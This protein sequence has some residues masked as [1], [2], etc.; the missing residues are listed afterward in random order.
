MARRNGT[1]RPWVLLLGATLV[2]AIAATGQ[3]AAQECS[4]TVRGELMRKEENQN[5]TDFSIAVEVETSAICA[6]V[7][8]ELRVIERDRGGQERQ[9]SMIKQSKVRDQTA[10]PMK[11]RY[12]LNK[13]ST[14]KEYFL[15][16]IRCRLCGTAP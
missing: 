2:V 12:R 5:S 10:N 15:E 11:I 13:G 16:V 14:V 4:A 8:W 1:I 6:N 9:K 7:D 3:V